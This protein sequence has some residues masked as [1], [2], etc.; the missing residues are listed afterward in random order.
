MGSCF[1]IG[2]AGYSNGIKEGNSGY[3]WELGQHNGQSSPEGLGEVQYVIIE[4]SVYMH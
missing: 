4:T 3:F 1:V 2:Y